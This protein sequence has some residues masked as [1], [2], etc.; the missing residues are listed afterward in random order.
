MGLCIFLTSLLEVKP[1]L[2]ITN[3]MSIIKKIVKYL[4][5]KF[6]KRNRLNNMLVFNDWIGFQIV[7]NGFYEI[8]ELETLKNSLNNK[9]KET[10]FLDIGSNIGNHSV[11]MSDFFESVK[12]FEPQIK[13]FKVLQLN[14]E[15]F[16]NITVY[17]YGIDEIER[18]T[19]FNIPINNIGSGSEYYEFE[20][21]FKEEVLLKPLG[22]EFS[23]NV[24]LIKIDVEGNEYGV[25]KTLDKVIEKSSPLITM[26]LHNHNHKKTEILNFLKTN[27]YGEV[28]VLKT[29]KNK[30]QKTYNKIFGPSKKLKK[31]DI[32]HVLSSNKNFNFLIFQKNNDDKLVCNNDK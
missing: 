26:E 4:F 32:N 27:D 30:V 22:K 6:N 16:K 28:F 13:T 19:I 31:L 3:D 10:T 18:K 14:T 2:S 7:V 12:S 23:E 15:K 25:L 1:V 11:F 9:L 17:N 24:G 21:S 8:N 29:P 20:N 5:I